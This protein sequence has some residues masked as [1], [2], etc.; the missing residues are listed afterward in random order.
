VAKLA[1]AG[2]LGEAELGHEGGLDPGR[3][4]HAGRVEEG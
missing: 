3:V 4:A 2:E 1:V